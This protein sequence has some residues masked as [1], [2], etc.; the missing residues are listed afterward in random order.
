MDSPECESVVHSDFGAFYRETWDRVYRPLAVIVRD[1]E[2]AAESVDEA[3]V[4]T[5]QKWSIVRTYD[6][7]VGWVYRVAS[8][9]AKNRL[10]RRWREVP[11]R[12]VE[13]SCE[14]GTPHPELITAISRLP[15][16]QRQVVVLRF[17][18]DW[19]LREVGDA[20]G[21]PEGTVKSRLHRALET[22]KEVIE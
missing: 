11:W 2:L 14:M 10:R 1:H 19:S 4:R 7:P 17:V 3:M 18:F 6:N 13:S 15:L 21:I 16:G 22:L 12:D 20:L 5:F 8:N 9:Y